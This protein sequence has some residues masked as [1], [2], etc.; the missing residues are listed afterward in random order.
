MALCFSKAKELKDRK[1][2]DICP[3][4]SK[5]HFNPNTLNPSIIYFEFFFVDFL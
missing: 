3:G 1:Y 2:G 5:T 4:K